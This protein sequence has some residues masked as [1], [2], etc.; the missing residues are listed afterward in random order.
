[1]VFVSGSPCG[2]LCASAL[3]SGCVRSSL[4]HEVIGSVPDLI[5]SIEEYM[6]VHDNEPRPLLSTATAESI[7]TK[8]GRVALN[9]WPTRPKTRGPSSKPKA[10]DEMA[11]AIFQPDAVNTRAET[12]PAT[13]G[14]ASRRRVIPTK[15]APIHGS[16]Q[17]VLKTCCPGECCGWFTC[18][19]ALM[20]PFPVRVWRRRWRR[21]SRPVLS[22]QLSDWRSN[23]QERREHQQATRRRTP[24][25]Q[26]RCRPG[27]PCEVGI[28]QEASIDRRQ[29]LLHSG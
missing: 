21:R 27:Q 1:M 26:R 15:K 13:T 22:S 3:A 7:L 20:P 8:V 6:K 12:S 17:G 18:C 4:G 16:A 5:S 11:S 25:T 10:I 9:N 23:R 29:H 14:K 24:S 2:D 28:W 19:S